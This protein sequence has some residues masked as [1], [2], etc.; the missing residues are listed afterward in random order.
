MKTF[1]SAIFI[2]FLF[3]LFGCSSSENIGHKYDYIEPNTAL[4]NNIGYLKIFTD[5]IM[6]KV[7][8][9][10]D[11][12]YEVYKGYSIYKRNGDFVKDIGKSYHLPKLVKLEEGDYVIIAELYKNIIQS[13][14]ISIEKGK[15]LEIDKNM[16]DNPIAIR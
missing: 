10:Q 8:Y 15:I 1:I 14:K 12:S 6:E 2:S 11:A 9:D 13:F 7:H 5:K 16:V 3:V 4:D